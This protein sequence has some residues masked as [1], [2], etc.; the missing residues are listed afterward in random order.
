VFGDGLGTD[1]GNVDGAH[2]ASGTY[3]VATAT[4]VISKTS[5]VINDPLNGTT[6]PKRIPGA[7]VRYTISIQNTGGTSAT[8][9]VASDPVPGDVTYVAG[10]ITLNGGAQTDA[11]DL[12]A[13]NY[14][15]T[16]PGAV[17]VNVGTIPS[18]ALPVN[19]TF[20]VT[21]D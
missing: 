5:A 11:N 2:S 7:L 13:S 17:T 10:T 18:G 12:D 3:T 21:V 1:D 4:F 9:V 19:I 6:N 16:T 14:G 20:D 15:V 8:N